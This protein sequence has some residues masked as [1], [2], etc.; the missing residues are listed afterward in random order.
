MRIPPPGRRCEL[1]GL[2]EVTA[3]EAGMDFRE[4]LYRRE[5]FLR[6]YEFHL[7]HKT[8]PGCVY[9]VMPELARVG[10]WDLEQRL[11]FAF[12]NGNTQ[13]PVTSW[14]IFR[15]FPEVRALATFAGMA[16][17]KAWWAAEQK[18]FAFDTDRRYFRTKFPEAVQ[19]YVDLLSGET[20]ASMFGAVAS[21]SDARAN[22]RQ[23]WAWG[24]SSL[25]YFGRL[26]LFSYL[27]YLRIMGV[28]VEC[29]RLFLDEL[30]ESKSH[31]NG[32]AKVLGRDDLDWHDSNPGFTG[33]YDARLMEWLTTEADLLLADARLR[34]H[35]QPFERDVGFFTLE[36]AFCTYKSWHR[37]NRRYPNV[38]ADMMVDRIKVGERAAGERLDV[39]WQAREAALPRALRL[40]DNPCDPGVVPEKQNHY[41]ETGQVIMMHTDWPCFAN[42]FNARVTARQGAA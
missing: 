3:L 8:S 12:I 18:T 27:E 25:I 33:R 15:R 30:K 11:W 10:N 6:F 19:R 40:E 9:F 21:S 20:Q 42:D 23:L 28:E 4:A 1:D 2:R 26:S 22:F 7:R 14:L 37:P 41:R 5:V 34:F 35:G 24:G 29:D 38:Y 39:F 32:L 17:F 31:R 13:N 36:S 16:K